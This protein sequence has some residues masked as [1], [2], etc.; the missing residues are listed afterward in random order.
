[1][2]LR[3]R[4][5]CKFGCKFCCKLGVTRCCITK[6]FNEWQQLVCQREPN[7][8]FKI[9]LINPKTDLITKTLQKTNVPK[10]RTKYYWAYNSLNIVCLVQP[11]CQKIYWKTLQFIQCIKDIQFSSVLSVCQLNHHRSRYHSWSIN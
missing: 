9:K 7:G 3:V 5:E 6:T 8:C 4:S 10:T 1:M 2:N 11:I